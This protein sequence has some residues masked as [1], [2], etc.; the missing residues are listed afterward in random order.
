MNRFPYT[1]LIL[2][3]WGLFSCERQDIAEKTE[4]TDETDTPVVIP[5]Q[6]VEIISFQQELSLVQLIPELESNPH[7]Q[8]ENGQFFIPL[9]TQSWSMD[10]TIDPIYLPAQTSDPVFLTA[11]QSTPGVGAW[12][13]NTSGVFVLNLILPEGCTKL[14]DADC[15]S[16]F[17]LH[18]A[19][20]ETTPYR[21]LILSKISIQFPS[22]LHATPVEGSIP[23]MEL[24]KEGKDIEFKLTSLY[25]PVGFVG[26]DGQ[27]YL[28]AQIGFSASVAAAAGYALDPSANPPASIRLAC[29]FESGRIDLPSC[30]LRLS[31]LIFPKE[32]QKGDPVP[33]PSFLSGEG[34]D[35]VLNDP[36][37]LIHYVQELPFYAYFEGSFPNLQD[38]PTFILSS[39]GNYLLMPRL[40]GWYRQGINNMD[41]PAMLDLFRAPGTE[42][43]L[44]PYMSFRTVATAEAGF[45]SSGKEYGMDVEAEWYIPLSYTGR[46]AGVS[47]Q[48]ET[49]HLD[50]DELNAPGTGTHEIGLTLM[51]TFPFHCVVTPVFTLDGQDPVYLED[52]IVKGW[53]GGPWFHH[54]FSPGKD[55]WRA[56][57]YFI[58]TPTD[59]LGIQFSRSHSLVLKDTRMTINLKEK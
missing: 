45:Y 5:P 51:S 7:I 57:L 52:I 17:R 33:C 39:S 27:H 14:H 43:K 59:G 23:A 22:W 37:I 4:E 42:G 28:S 20:D 41:V 40:D 30:G 13:L 15:Q 47:G 48:T 35:I 19:L 2:L 3:A 16:T 55:H 18:L 11:E 25:D 10:Y 32:E 1:F 8:E 53:S 49:L 29:F 54:A 31:N 58:V 36:R 6:R 46:L 38:N 21:K 26:E 12:K 34:S 9:G 44:I 50:G 24:T 56:S